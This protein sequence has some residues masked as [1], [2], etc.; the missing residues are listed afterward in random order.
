MLDINLIRQNPQKVKDGCQKKQVKVDIDKLLELDRK[1]VKLLQ[2]IESLKHQRNLVSKVKKEGGSNNKSPLEPDVL[3]KAKIIKRKIKPLEEQLRLIQKEFEEKMLEIP[4]LPFPEVPVGESENDNIVLKKVGKI[5][6]FDFRPKDHLEIGEKLNLIDV[7]KAAK[8]SGQRFSYLKNEAVLLEF[9]I[10]KFVFES[11]LKEGFHPI[12]PPVLLKENIA[13]GTGYLE[14]N[15]KEEAYYIP[16]DHLYL[17]GTSEQSL[18]AMGSNEIFTEEELPKRYL[19]FSTCFRREAGSYGKDT[20][21][22]LRVHQFDKLEMFSFT[23]P[24]E[25][26]KEHKF[27]LSLEEKLMQK[28]N[29]PYQVINICTADLGRPAAAKYDI[30]VWLPSQEK[31]RETHSTSN[32]TDFQARRLNIRYREKGSGK[33]KFLHTVNGTAFAIGRLLIAILENYQQKDGKVK[34]PD[35]LQKY[36]NFKTIP[37]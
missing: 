31:Y 17:V 5:P 7:E 8:V 1:R 16:K 36:L 26:K 24:Q 29:L 28:L 30:E 23:T 27:F 19:G 35:A 9:A 18:A 3:K 20:R 22:I 33:L 2:E 13:R 34:I 4:N 12:L 15:D 14:L 10:I 25:S 21:G 32:C 37:S 6:K 11:L